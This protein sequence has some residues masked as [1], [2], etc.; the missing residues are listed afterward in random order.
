MIILRF[1]ALLIGSAVLFGAPFLLLPDTPQSRPGDT[2]SVIADC[3]LILLV[4]S[5]YFFVGVLG[6]RMR[7]SLRRRVVAGVLLSFPVMIGGFLI[8]SGQEPALLPYV[9]PLLCSTVLMYIA[10]VF[11]TNRRRTSRSMR[12]KEECDQVTEM[13]IEASQTQT[14]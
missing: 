10:F 7:K 14:V 11:Q 6:H 3:A 5:G 9:G 13:P 4:V 1:I 2:Y 12:P 8:V